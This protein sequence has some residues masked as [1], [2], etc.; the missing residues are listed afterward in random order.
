[1]YRKKLSHL[2][3]LI[4]NCFVIMIGFYV[5]NCLINAFT[6]AAF[7]A[8]LLLMPQSSKQIVDVC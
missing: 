7:K 8:Q 4:K 6:A 3:V 5:R 2:T 1:M